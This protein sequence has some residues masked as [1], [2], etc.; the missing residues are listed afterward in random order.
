MSSSYLTIDM[1]TREALRVAHEKLQFIGTIDRSYDDSF[2]KTGA[3][4]GSALRI[5]LPNQFSIRTSG[6]S[7]DVQDTTEATTSVTVANQYG[8]DMRFY[9]DERS[10][11]IDDFSHRYIEP[12]VARLVS[13]VESDCLATA[14]KAT[15]NLVG[16]AGTIV[17]TSGDITAI[18]NARAR[19]NQ[20]LAP[21][22]DNRV[23]QFDSVTMATVAANLKS[24]FQPP[25]DVAKAFREGMYARSAMADLYENE[26]T[27]VHT[28]GADHTGTTDA[29]AAVTDGGTNVSADTASPVTFT[30]GTVFTIAGVYACHPETKASLGYLQQFTNTAGTGSGGDMT[31][32]PA[33]IL[34]GA[35]QN[36]CKSDGTALATTDFNSQTITA[37]GSTTTSYR[38]N[39]MYHKEAFTFVTA[40][41]PIMAESEYCGR[42]TQDGISLRVWQGADIVND[43]MLMRIDL[44]WGFA[45]IRPEW[46]VRITN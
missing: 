28:T 23:A 32:S 16:T 33:T 39:L 36:L 14:T 21:K 1:V 19:L 42:R 18:H 22:D 10:L 45:A 34:T 24:I 11:A 37:V 12:A 31:I 2:A 46:A 6:R 9:S 40:D 38:Q 25:A 26:R 44:L 43:R 8:V 13:K 4:I 35:K 30:V 5:R 17:G 7:M 41:L 29:A 20:M 27:Y 3:K 15:Y